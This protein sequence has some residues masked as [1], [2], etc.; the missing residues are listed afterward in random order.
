DEGE[1][2][3]PETEN[4]AALYGVD[5]IAGDADHFYD[6][7]ERYGEGL[8]CDLY[9]QSLN[10][11]E[12][13]CEFER[14]L[15]D[16]SGLSFAVDGDIEA[17]DVRLDDVHADAPTGDLADLFSGAET[18]PEDEEVGLL[19]GHFRRFLGRDDA[20]VDGGFLEA[21]GVHAGAVVFDHDDDVVAFVGGCQPDFTDLGLSRGASFLRAFDAVVGRVSN[22]VYQRVADLLDERFIELGFLTLD[23]EVDLFVKLLGEVTDEAGELVEDPADLDH[24]RAHD[25]RLELGCY[26]VELSARIGKVSEQVLPVRDGVTVFDYLNEAVTAQHELADKVHQ[27]VEAA[28]FHADRVGGRFHFLSADA[29]LL[30]RW[31]LGIG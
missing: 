18:S 19:V 14:K 8:V 4:L 28:H 26:E 27:V 12:R 21:F 2:L 24:A 15:G 9:Q 30:L 25:G 17:R 5:L 10:D 16:F 29:R 7:A 1:H 31:R 13:R 22:K 23:Y 11:G 20:F 6:G 3:V